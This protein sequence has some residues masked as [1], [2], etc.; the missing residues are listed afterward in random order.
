MSNSTELLPIGVH[1]LTGF[2]IAMP[3]LMAAGYYAGTPQFVLWLWSEQG[4]LEVGQVL[5]LLTAVGI[6]VVTLAGRGRM[7]AIRRAGLGR[8][9]LCMGGLALL[10]AVIAGEEA[11]WGQ[12]YVGWSTPESWG[13]LNDQHETNLHNIGSWADQ[14]PRA[15]VELTVILF[16]IFWPLWDRLSNVRMPPAWRVLLPPT[17]VLPVALLAEAVRLLERAP[18]MLGASGWA[19]LPRPSEIQEFYFYTFFALCMFAWR[20]RVLQEL[21]SATDASP[22]S[23]PA[24]LPIQRAA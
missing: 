10:C 16:G 13:E 23:T 19:A 21:A 12:H 15:V 2:L 18:R 17:N 24:P 7:A 5:V 8:V 4:P 6:G 14:K 1:R 11:S 20:C 22:K 9:A 3:L